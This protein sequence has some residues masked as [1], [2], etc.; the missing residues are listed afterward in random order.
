MFNLKV[1]VFIICTICYNVK[2]DYTFCPLSLYK[3]R[4]I[5]RR[6]IGLF[7]QHISWTVLLM[8]TDFSLWGRK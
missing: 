4:K 5:F 7:I 1:A 6:S 3:L 8:G 2:N